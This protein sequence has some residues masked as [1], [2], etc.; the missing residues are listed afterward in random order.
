MKA[1]SSRTGSVERL[2]GDGPGRPPFAAIHQAFATADDLA[3]AVQ[4][5]L[6][7]L[8]GEQPVLDGDG[9]HSSPHGII[10]MLQ[11]RADETR[12]RLGRALDRLNVAQKEIGQ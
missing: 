8:F 11:D 2:V 5:F 9:A 1:D 12:R 6:D 7:T 3:S 4:A 10:P